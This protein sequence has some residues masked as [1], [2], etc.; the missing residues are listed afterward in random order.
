MKT[1]TLNLT[2]GRK[3]YGSLEDC[4]ILCRIQLE[5]GNPDFTQA[6]LD[7]L[8]LARGQVAA[9]QSQEMMT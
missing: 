5:N 8:D 7:G 2:R 1:V 3:W 9:L 6:Q 4:F